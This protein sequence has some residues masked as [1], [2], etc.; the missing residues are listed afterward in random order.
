FAIYILQHAVKQFIGI[1]KTKPGLEDMKPMWGKEALILDIKDT[2]WHLEQEG[3]L[4][5]PVTPTETLEGMSEEE[6]R[7]MLDKLGEIVVPPWLELPWALVAVG[8]VGVLGV[9]AALAL[10]PRK[11]E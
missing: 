10:A 11:K 6:L 4:E 2:E 7:V 8:A 3:R 9:G 1:F 5:R